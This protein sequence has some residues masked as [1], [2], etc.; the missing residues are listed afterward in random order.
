MLRIAKYIGAGLAVATLLWICGQLGYRYLGYCRYLT[1]PA[2]C[3][4]KMICW[5]GLLGTAG[6]TILLIGFLWLQKVRDSG[7]L[8][9]CTA[10]F[11]L[12]VVLRLS[13]LVLIFCS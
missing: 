11:L 12:L 9:A 2:A 13:H 4:G 3:P 1:S 6:G 5:G 10:A 8:A 7:Y